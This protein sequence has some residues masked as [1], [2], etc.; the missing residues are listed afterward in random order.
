[1]FDHFKIKETVVLKHKYLDNNIPIHLQKTVEKQNIGK[2]FEKYG[3][4]V[5]IYD[6]EIEDSEISMANCSN[7]FTVK[8]KIKTIFPKIDKIFKAIS[9][10]NTI[11][12][13]NFHGA[14]L[15]IF[16]IKKKNGEIVPIQIFLTNGIKKENLLIFENCDCFISCVSFPSKCFLS[17]IVIDYLVYYNGLFKIAGKHIH[18]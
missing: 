7:R 2:C 17:D 18:S 11:H 15:N 8:Y 4:V 13:S 9:V 5:E 10:I 14:L 12:Q 16:E 1:M 6:L 3:Y